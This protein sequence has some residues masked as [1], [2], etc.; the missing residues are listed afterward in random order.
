MAGAVRARLRTRVLERLRH[1]LEAPH[2]AIELAEDASLRFDGDALGR[3][4][5]GPDLLEPKVAASRLDLLDADE[6]DRVRQRLERWRDELVS[7]LFAPLDR[8][9]AEALS[10]AARGLVYALRK[11]LGTVD[12][13]EVADNVAALGPDDRKGLARLDVRFGHRVIYVQSLFRRE[14]QV[15]RAALYAV[16]ARTPVRP[17]P[18]EGRPA[19]PFAGEDVDLLRLLG[20]RRAGRLAVRADLLERVVGEVRR[21]RGKPGP[22]VVEKLCSWLGASRDDVALVVRDLSPRGRAGRPSSSRPSGR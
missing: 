16:A 3:I 15:T 2:A 8:P 22:E 18:A 13:L 10:P 5:A 7:G 14:A 11:G 20:Y 9:A 17:P 12:A 6:R 19:L 1:L 4:E 21:A